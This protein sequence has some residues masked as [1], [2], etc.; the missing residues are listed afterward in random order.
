M[1]GSHLQAL[2]KKNLLIAK[3]TFVLTTIEVLAPIV[4]MLALLGLKTLFKK[5]K[6]PLEDDEEDIHTNTS[7]AISNSFSMFG[8]KSTYVQIFTS[9]YMCNK[10]NNIVFIGKNFPSNLANKF[11]NRVPDDMKINFKYYENYETLSDY[12]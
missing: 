12:I 2:L 9:L 10:R 11:I 4:I 7:F 6:I 5:E 1:L 3:S 8:G